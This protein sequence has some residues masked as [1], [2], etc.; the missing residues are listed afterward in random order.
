MENILN[1]RAMQLKFRTMNRPTGQL[2]NILYFSDSHISQV[3]NELMIFLFPINSLIIIL[4]LLLFRNC[5]TF[6]IAELFNYYIALRRV[7]LRMRCQKISK[8]IAHQIFQ[9]SGWDWP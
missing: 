1:H 2:K 8:F 5:E 4:A 7:A 6:I 9:N 3:H